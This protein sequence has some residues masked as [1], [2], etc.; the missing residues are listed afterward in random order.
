[1][2]NYSLLNHTTSI[3]VGKYPLKKHFINGKI[4]GSAQRVDK[5]VIPYF[6]LKLILYLRAL[7]FWILIIAYLNKYT[8]VN[9]SL[10][11]TLNKNILT[12]DNL[13]QA[14]CFLY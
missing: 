3:F 7:I 14:E 8:F 13:I 11:Q 1:M 2:V 4:A 10:N 12:C 6:I 5:N 9:S